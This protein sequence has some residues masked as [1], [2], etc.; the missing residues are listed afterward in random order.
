MAKFIQDLLLVGD[1]I[2]NELGNR[3]DKNSGSWQWL[4]GSDSM[5]GFL[6]KRNLYMRER[7]CFGSA[8]WACF[9]GVCVLA[10]RNPPKTTS[11][12]GFQLAT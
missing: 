4:T 6:V 10:Q 5:A 3:W 9:G 8:I 11:R 2:S 7:R 12:C 1:K